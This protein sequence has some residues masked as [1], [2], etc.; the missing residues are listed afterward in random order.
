MEL[1]WWIAPVEIGG[2]LALA[3]IVVWRAR[4]RQARTYT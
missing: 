2:G 4:M 3:G 1:S